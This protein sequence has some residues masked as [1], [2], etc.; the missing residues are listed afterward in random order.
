[1]EATKKK[2]AYLKPEMTKF[3]MKAEGTFMVASRAQVDV[4]VLIHCF[5]ISNNSYLEGGKW[6]ALANENSTEV[7][8]TYFK[9]GKTPHAD[10]LEAA[11]FL[12]G[13]CL[14][15]RRATSSECTSN[16]DSEVTIIV[17]RVNCP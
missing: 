14:E 11:G 12:E 1:M 7:I 2:K 16:N 6:S 8:S 3:E 4:P 9:N 17:T 13:D 15:V 10:Q 5:N